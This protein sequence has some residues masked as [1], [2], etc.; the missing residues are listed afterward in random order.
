MPSVNRVAN[1]Y[2]TSVMRSS[3]VAPACRRRPLSFGSK[4]KPPVQPEI[5]RSLGKTI[6][7]LKQA[8]LVRTFWIKVNSAPAGVESRVEWE[9]EVVP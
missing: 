9:G 3:K 5:I 6:E 1:C 7:E 8:D 2:M 4:S